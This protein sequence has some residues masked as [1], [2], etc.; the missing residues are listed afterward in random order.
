MSHNEKSVETD[1]VNIVKITEVR[2]ID[3]IIH[4]IN[5]YNGDI[6]IFKVYKELWDKA[7]E[8]RTV[9]D[10]SI[11]VGSEEKDKAKEENKTAKIFI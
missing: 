2:D 10:L 1:F 4:F 9:Q 5:T 8:I 7:M 6:H 3:Y 11:T